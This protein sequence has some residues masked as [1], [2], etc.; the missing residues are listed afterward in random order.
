MQSTSPNTKPHTPTRTRGSRR[1]PPPSPGDLAFFAETAPRASPAAPKTRP[2]QDTLGPSAKGLS[3]QETLEGDP[4]GLPPPPPLRPRVGSRVTARQARFSTAWHQAVV[5]DVRVINGRTHVSVI[6][7]DDTTTHAI[8]MSRIRAAEEPAPPPSP[9]G[10][11]PGLPFA[12]FCRGARVMAR[13]TRHSPWHPATISQRHTHK[14]RLTITVDWDDTSEGPSTAGIPTTRIKLFQIDAPRPPTPPAHPTWTHPTWTHPPHEGQH[15]P[16]FSTRPPTTVTHAPAHDSR[17]PL[18]GRSATRNTSQ[19]APLTRP[20]LRQTSDPL[21]P[22]REPPHIPTGAPVLTV[23]ECWSSLILSGAKTMEIRTCNTLKRGTV[24]LATSGLGEIWGQVD[25][26]DSTRLTHEEWHSR[27]SAH[28][29]GTRTDPTILPPFPSPPPYAWH[30][31]NATRYTNPVPMDRPRGPITWVPFVPTALDTPP[32]EIRRENPQI[33]APS[34]TLD[35]DRPTRDAT[36]AE[37]PADPLRGGSRHAQPVTHDRPEPDDTGNRA[38]LT[39]QILLQ[40]QD[41]VRAAMEPSNH[42]PTMVDGAQALITQLNRHKKSR[43]AYPFQQ[44]E[45]TEAVRRDAKNSAKKSKRQSSHQAHPTRTQTWRH[46]LTAKYTGMSDAQGSAIAYGAYVPREG[47]KHRTHINADISSELG[48]LAHVSGHPSPHH[49]D[50]LADMWRALQT[51]GYDPNSRL[52]AMVRAPTE[53]RAAIE[54]KMHHCH[55]DRR[56]T[57]H[58]KLLAA[59]AALQSTGHLVTQPLPSYSADVDRARTLGYPVGPLTEPQLRLDWDYHSRTLGE[60]S[61]TDLP[62]V[63]DRSNWPAGMAGMIEN[64]TRSS[65]F[66]DTPSEDPTPG[67]PP[68]SLKNMGLHNIVRGAHFAHCEGGAAV[69]KEA[70]IPSNWGIT[71]HMCNGHSAAHNCGHSRKHVISGG[72]KSASN[73]AVPPKFPKEWSHMIPPSLYFSA[74]ASSGNINPTSLHGRCA[75]HIGSGTGSMKRALM[76]TGA[77]VIGVDIRPAI[78]AGTRVERTTVVADYDAF[79][80][81]MG[82][83]IE[84]SIHSMGFHRADTD[85]IAFDADCSTRSQ[86]TMNMN[87]RCRDSTTGHVDH[88]KPGSEEAARRDRIDSKTIQWMDS[89]LHSHSDDECI[90]HATAWPHGPGGW[91]FSDADAHTILISPPRWDPGNTTVREEDRLRA[92]SLYQRQCHDGRNDP[93]RRGTDGPNSRGRFCDPSTNNE[94][95]SHA[96]APAT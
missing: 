8:P 55:G 2:Q 13:Q 23:N 58:L 56:P 67:V 92:R 49:H 4:T 93:S 77:F 40:H 84:H 30:L 68:S 74:L 31:S 57:Q 22:P 34:A 41:Q 25:I 53:V 48:W 44:D 5:S 19:W 12:H 94:D 83:L 6:W 75:V 80:G 82:T 64:P 14:G 78:D 54:L 86:M 26:L 45:I 10:P 15:G 95:P 35:S 28:R 21:P 46:M 96:G 60:I 27:A 61:G 72:G 47:G 71:T 39:M 79:E 52:P 16:G 91:G 29:V 90:T 20:S 36:D 38:A 85:L 66:R 18:R 33:T 76:L 69:E 63:I 87:G 7:D 24:Y 65:F 89:V 43:T 81:R 42:S 17:P 59:T 88:T 50:D 9:S 1:H 51:Q 37:S 73:N 32:A 70:Y 62:T 11:L 3:P